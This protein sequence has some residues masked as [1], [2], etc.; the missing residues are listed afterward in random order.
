MLPGGC[1]ALPCH[2]VGLGSIH[3][4]AG[5]TGS[6]PEHRALQGT[7]VWDK[8][9]GEKPWDPKTLSLLRRAKVR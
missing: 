4:A 6:K 3:N 2:R 8:E 9:M 7:A 5:T 1:P